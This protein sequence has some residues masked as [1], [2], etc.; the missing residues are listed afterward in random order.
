MSKK[1]M[2][3]ALAVA[4]LFALPSAASA[5]EIHFPG[6]TSFSGSG[7]AGA[8]VAAN[9]PK[10]SCTGT[11]VSGKFNSGSTTTGEVTL[12][13]AGCT[14][15]LLGIK[16]NC[17]TTGDAEK[18]ITSS[19]VFHLITTSTGKP[20]ILVTPVT[21]T[22]LCLG[23]SRI[24]VT[25][26]GIIGTI[27]SPACGAKSKT[28]NLAFEQTGGTQKHLEYTGTKYDLLAHTESSSGGITSTNT[29]GLE[30]TATIN[31]AT[32]GTLECT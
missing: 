2:L 6:V 13:F 30:G 26:N 3:L 4:A 32:E 17:N 1:M 23:F 11:T 15:E 21:T 24:S 7:P 9:E 10:I 27:T 5:Q 18:T 29:A 31:S 12:T 28:M 19:G 16:G 20:G 8:L 14:A 22:V 25:G